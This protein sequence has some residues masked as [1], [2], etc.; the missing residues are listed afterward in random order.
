M[1]SIEVLTIQLED[2]KRSFDEEMARLTDNVFG[3]NPNDATLAE[4]QRLRADATNH[5]ANQARQLNGKIRNIA[6]MNLK[7]TQQTIQIQ[8]PIPNNITIGPPVAE[9]TI[10]QTINDLIP[11]ID[12]QP[13]LITGQAK[14]IPFLP[15][16]AAVGGL[17]LIFAVAR[18]K[19]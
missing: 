7:T 8:P 10:K 18:R 2:A 14:Q 6:E 4:I 17:L 13:P 19:K 16:T 12:T 5:Y 9:P 3:N 11:K 15:I 1:D